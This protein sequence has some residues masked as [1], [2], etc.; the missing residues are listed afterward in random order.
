MLCLHQKAK[1]CQQRKDAARQAQAQGE[2]PQYG[3]RA[4]AIH[5]GSAAVLCVCSLND[6]TN[7]VIS[8][9]STGGSTG[10]DDEEQS[11]SWDETKKNTFLNEGNSLEVK[12]IEL[13]TKLKFD[14]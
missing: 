14:R 1:L 11:P 3:R 12:S 7:F 2:A 10:E 8:Y 4:F 5:R 13:S 9:Q 6:T